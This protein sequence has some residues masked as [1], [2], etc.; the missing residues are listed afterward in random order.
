MSAASLYSLHSDDAFASI[1]NSENRM[2][3]AGNDMRETALL[4]REVIL[5]SHAAMAEADRL[6]ARG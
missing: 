1:R 3:Q 4:T 6:L 5:R 2:I